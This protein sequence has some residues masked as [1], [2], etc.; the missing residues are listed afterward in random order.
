MVRSLINS[1]LRVFDPLLELVYPTYC[2]G[3]GRHGD[4][5][6]PA[7]AQSLVRIDSGLSCPVCGRPVGTASVCGECMTRRKPFEQ[8]HFGFSYE[9]PLREAMHAF[10]FRGRKDVGRMLVRML[11]DEIVPLGAL[12]DV[13]VPM[14]VTEKRLRERGFN[15]SYIIGQEMAA[16][17]GKPLVYTALKKV[18]ETRDQY[19][20]SKDERRRNIRGAFAVARKERDIIKKN[21]LLVDDLY[22]TGNTAAEAALTLRRAKAGSVL[23]FALARTP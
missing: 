4:V 8:G 20:L 17:T 7:C 1:A 15:Q 5:F 12:F 9:G 2:A 10:K 3:C 21:V 16:M 18:R 13:I 11:Q 6:C 23:L 22:T 19:T 14:P